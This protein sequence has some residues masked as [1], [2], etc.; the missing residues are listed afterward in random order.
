MSGIFKFFFIFIFSSGT[1]YKHLNYT[2]PVS[3]SKN[4]AVHKMEVLHLSEF[5]LREITDWIGSVVLK[6]EI[7][8][9]D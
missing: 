8:G 2:S 4:M 3:H 7:R 6:E 1:V 9:G 5:W